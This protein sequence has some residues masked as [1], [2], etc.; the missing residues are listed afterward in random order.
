[1]SREL[2]ERKMRLIEA[3]KEEQVPEKFFAKFHYYFKR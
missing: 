2:Q 3:Q 1:M